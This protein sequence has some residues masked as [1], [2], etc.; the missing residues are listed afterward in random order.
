[1]C[2]TVD[3]WLLWYNIT[4]TTATNLFTV[5]H[6]HVNA[7]VCYS[8]SFCFF[9]FL[10]IAQFQAICGEVTC[11]PSTLIYNSSNMF[12]LNDF[13]FISFRMQTHS[14]EE[15][16]PSILAVNAMQKLTNRSNSSMT[17][18]NRNKQNNKNKIIIII[19]NIQRMCWINWKKLVSNEK[20]SVLWRSSLYTQLNR[21]ESYVWRIL[22]IELCRVC[23]VPW[24]VVCQ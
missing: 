4:T 7:S 17:P 9:C 14:L 13:Q 22:Q 2:K 24:L 23:C 16:I 20:V 15:P 8:L 19:I 12:Y 18:K 11:I 1:M 21:I 6:I 3:E 10:F 5:T